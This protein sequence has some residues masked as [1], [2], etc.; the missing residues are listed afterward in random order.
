MLLFEARPTKISQVSRPFLLQS[1]RAESRLGQG[2]LPRQMRTVG[3]TARTREYLESLESFPRARGDWRGQ[4][5]VSF[6]VRA[7]KRMHR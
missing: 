3:K 7:Q 2:C 1:S 5:P 4:F 6:E